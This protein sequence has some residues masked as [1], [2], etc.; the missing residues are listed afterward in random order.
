MIEPLEQRIAPAGLLNESGFTT[1]VINS[2]ILVTAGHGLSTSNTGGSYLLY[3]EQ[4]QA[5]VFTTDLNHNNQVD[6]DEI[7][8][9]A[10]GDHL[11]M[12]SFVDIHG[13]V[14]TNLQAD[15]T[16]SD[17][18][19]NANNGRDGKI[20]LNSH[21]D[22][23]ELRSVAATDL[24]DPTQVSNRLALSSYSIFGN[25]YAGSGFGATD[26]GLVID[27]TG[28]ALQSAKFSGTSG[29][30]K[31]VDSSPVIG[32]IKTG[33]AGSG[34]L[35]NFGTTGAP[36]D[37]RGQLQNFVPQPNTVGGDITNISSTEKFNLGTLQAGNGGFGAR[38]GSI[39][40]VSIPGD[41]AGGYALIAGDGGAGPVG[42]SGG[43][44]V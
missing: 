1:A 43:S 15:G 27:T 9:I 40:N 12:I 39:I 11:R 16:L 38:G 41:T 19:N 31:W 22:K 35:F 10:A 32:S 23:F 33:T 37:V 34:E 7:T 24:T 6:F 18:D 30:I 20:L 36:S 2:T 42:S 4:G 13:D 25:I 29:S 8:G 21:I 26:G 28:K 3:V 5:L 44:I 14:V 17:S